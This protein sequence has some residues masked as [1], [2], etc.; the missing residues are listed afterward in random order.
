MSKTVTQTE[1]PLTDFYKALA[2]GNNRLAFSI[3]IPRSEV[4]YTRAHL[5]DVF[6]RDFSLDYVER[7][8]YLEGMLERQ[9]VL[10]PDRRRDWELE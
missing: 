4:F 1:N 8:L 10:D 3:H 9:D 5:R 2:D 7:C 6:G